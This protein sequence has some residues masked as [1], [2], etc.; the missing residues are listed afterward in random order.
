MEF[1]GHCYRF[2]PLKKTWAEADFCCSEFSARLASI[3]SWEEDVFVYDLVNSCVPGIPA[4][5]WTV[6]MTTDRKKKN[7]Y[8]ERQQWLAHGMSNHH[9]PNNIVTPHTNLEK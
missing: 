7:M 2:F 3:H 9:H 1:K 4:D 5:I 8:I 6:L